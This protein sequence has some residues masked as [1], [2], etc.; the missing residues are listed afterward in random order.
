MK[1]VNLFTLLSFW[2]LYNFL[3]SHKTEKE[4]L[5]RML[6]LLIEIECDHV[7]SS[8]KNDKK[9]HAELYATVYSE[10]TKDI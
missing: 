6:M 2:T 8:S 5:R 7:L 10:C 1:I 3:S 4:K 9:D